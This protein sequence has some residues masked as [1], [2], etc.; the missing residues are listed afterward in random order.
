MYS[1]TCTPLIEAFREAARAVV[2]DLTNLSPPRKN[3]PIQRQTIN[4]PEQYGRLVAGLGY[5]VDRVSIEPLRQYFVQE[6]REWFV[7]CEA[8]RM[9]RN[10]LVTAYNGVLQDISTENADALQ[11]IWETKEGQ[12]SCEAFNVFGT[13][14]TALLDGLDDSMTQREIT[15]CL[16]AIRDAFAPAAAALT[17]DDQALGAKI[18]AEHETAL[19][20]MEA[21]L[22]PP[23]TL[24]PTVE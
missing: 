16:Q 11:L 22:H 2:A 18:A 13:A 1:A 23:V 4:T 8:P 5:A 9:M 21:T 15:E 3:Q 6:L 19:Q 20:H 12:A 14:A 24:P 17:N 10:D 7:N